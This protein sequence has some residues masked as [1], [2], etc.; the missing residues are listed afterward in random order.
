MKGWIANTR[1]DWSDFLPQKQFWPE[2]NFWNLTTR[3]FCE[4]DE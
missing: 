1:H 2:V 4:R 3:G